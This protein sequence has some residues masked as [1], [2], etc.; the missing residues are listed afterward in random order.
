MIV[1][2]QNSYDDIKKMLNTIRKIT[3]SSPRKPII[4]QN[5]RPGISTEDS[6]VSPVEMK[7]PQPPTGNEREE[8]DDFEV[9]NNLEVVFKGSSDPLDMVLKDDEKSKISQ[10]VDDFRKEVSEL[11]EFNKLILSPNEAEL[12]GIIPDINLSFIF[13][14]GEKS[15]LSFGHIAEYTDEIKLIIDKLHH[16]QEKF[17]NTLNDLLL[18]RREN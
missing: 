16:F 4:E 2:K 3:E 14:T 9:I 18:T 11:G 15:G 10:L 5:Y 8:G 1:K 7:Q 6:Y 17:Q 13:S 12:A